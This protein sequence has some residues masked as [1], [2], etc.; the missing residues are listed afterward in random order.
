MY[1]TLYTDENFSNFENASSTNLVAEVQEYTTQYEILADVHKVDIG[2]P[3]MIID[4]IES[5]SQV[6]C[7]PA[8]RRF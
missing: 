3:L 5:S 1:Y 8:Y 6:S 4:R 7:G 2:L